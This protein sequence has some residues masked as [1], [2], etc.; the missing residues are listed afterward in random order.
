MSELRL[1][2]DVAVPLVVWLLM[3]VVGLE[4]RPADFRRVLIYPK[5]VAVATLAQLL[6]LPMICAVLIRALD[7][8]PHIV[9]GMILLAAC[10]GGAISNVYTYLARGN[11]ALSVTLTAVSGLVALVTT[12]LLTVAGIALFL[13]HREAIEVPIARM[14]IQL[15][16]MLVVPVAVGMALR[17]AWPSAIEGHA[18][19]LR[20]VSLLGIGALVGAILMDQ[21][22]GLAADAGPV[23]LAAVPFSL[24]AMA[25]GWGV[26]RLLGLDGRDRLTL[27][28]E[29]AA[30]NLAI[31]AVLGMM[32][33]GRLEL[34]LFATLFFLTQIPM[35]LL[36]IAVLG[37]R[38]R[39][40]PRLA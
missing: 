8:A 12:P 30:R 25:A 20:R 15:T 22:D 39:S 6:L 31:A 16:I 37:H 11:V 3:L 36:I 2:S 18:Q 24:L 7:P 34:T 19:W 10:P 14:A 1:I 23:M 28:L 33:L 4:L 13:D 21:R 40:D 5:V 32:V 27:L 29:F 38:S 35:V 17:Q 9:A 26:G